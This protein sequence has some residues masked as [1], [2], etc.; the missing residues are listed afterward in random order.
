VQSLS[1]W[2]FA[3]GVLATQNV[4]TG[5]PVAGVAPIGVV[6]AAGTSG[7]EQ[8]PPGEDAVEGVWAMCLPTIVRVSNRTEPTG[9]VSTVLVEVLQ[10]R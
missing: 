8:I 7:V 9:A 5:L 6:V 10:S 4:D 3:P 1:G 2:G